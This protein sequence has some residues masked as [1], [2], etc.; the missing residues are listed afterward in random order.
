MN[1]M[2]SCLQGVH[3]SVEG[4][5]KRLKELIIVLSVIKA[6]IAV[7]GKCVENSLK[8]L[9]LSKERISRKNF[10]IEK[11]RLRWTLTHKQ[12][13]GEIGFLG[14]GDVLVLAGRPS[15]SFPPLPPGTWHTWPIK[16]L[17]H[18]YWMNEMRRLKFSF[19]KMRYLKLVISHFL[20]NCVFI[21]FLSLSK[22][23]LFIF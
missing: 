5:F 1:K 8:W 14:R 20:C 12:E 11:C 7:W 17:F 13:R 23:Y 9:H 3:K 6:R 10:L 4:G 21:S 18:Y 15:P 16:V 22:V 19:K 2:W